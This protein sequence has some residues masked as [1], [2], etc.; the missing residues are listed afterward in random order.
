MIMIMVILMVVMMMGLV[1]VTFDGKT[2]CLYFILHRLIE[3]EAKVF[4][5]HPWMEIFLV[6]ITLLYTNYFPTRLSTSN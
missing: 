1:I 6:K 3:W 5:N 2:T 4:Q